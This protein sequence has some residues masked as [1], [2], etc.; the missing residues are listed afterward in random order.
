[1]NRIL[2]VVRMQL[3]NKQTFVWV[4]LIVLGGAFAISLAIY[5]ILFSAGATGTFYGGGAQAPLWYFAVIGAQAL[6]MTFPFSQAMSVTRREFFLGTMLTAVLTAAML[7]VI[8][9]I[10][11]LIETATGG[12]WFNGYFFTVGVGWEP[13]PVLA[14]VFYFAIAMLFFVSGFWGATIFKRFGTL[15]LVV[16]L[17]GVAA[18][19]VLALFVVTRLDAWPSVIDW[20]AS[21]GLG[22]ITL[23][24]A[25]IAAVLAAIAFPTLRRATP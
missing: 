7:A 16:T 17:V 21:I 6:T 11:G 19:I 10:G 13:G 14:G 8:F 4:P 15:W 23:L 12:W 25:G 2:K 5:G 22:G 3:T 20:V 9:V 18:I 1:M 24:I